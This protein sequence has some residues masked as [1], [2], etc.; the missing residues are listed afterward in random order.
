[1]GRAGH[2]LGAVPKGIVYP[3]TRDDLVQCAA[4]VRAIRAGELDRVLLPEKP[5]DILAQHIVATVASHA[6]P[7][8]DAYVQPSLLDLPEAETGQSGIAEDDLWRLVRRAYPYRGLERAEFNDV[9]KMLSDGI[10]TRMGRRSALLHHDRIHRRLRARRGA[11]LSA[12]TNGGAIPDTADYDVVE[13]PAET[14]VGKVNEDF[15]IESLAGD[16]FLLGNRSWRIHRVSSGKVWVSDAKGSPPTI[17]FWLGEA[18]ARTVELSAA[19]SDLRREI[20]CRF[21]E[22]AAAVRWLAQECC[23]DE[24]AAQQVVTYVAETARALGCV[25]TADCIVAERFFDEAGGMQLVLH[26]PLGGRINR[27]WGLA[28]RKRFCV[29]FN[30][31]IQAAATDDGI[32]LSLGEQHSFPLPEVFSWLRISSTE[33]ALRQAALAS[34]MFVNRWRWNA[35]RALAVQRFRNGKKVPMAIQRFRAEDLLAAVFPEQAGCQDNRTGPVE[36]P[37]HP[38]VDQTMLDCLYEAMDLEGLLQMLG[39]IERGE[40]R[41]VAVETTAPSPMAHEIL[42]ANPY[43][44]LDD[45]PLEERRARAVALR[46][47]DPDLAAGLGVLDP[48]AIE[49]VRAQAWPDLRDSDELHDFLLSVCLLPVPE[50]VHWRNL[51]DELIRSGRGVQASWAAHGEDGAR[52]VYVATERVAVIRVLLPQAQIEPN[53]QYGAEDDP[54]VEEEAIRRTVQGWMEVLGPT[55]AQRL[56]QLLGLS[57][58]QVER[59]LLALEASGNVLR[60]QFETGA[61]DSVRSLQWCDRALLARIHRLTLGRLRSEIEPVSA[62]EFIKFLFRW[63]HVDAESRLRGREGLLAVIGQLQGVEL[64][65]PAWEQAVLATRIEDYD[66]AELEQ[67]CLAGL[68]AWGRIKSDFDDGS[69]LPLEPRQRKNRKRTLSRVAPIAFLIRDNLERF[70]EP[71]TRP[72]EEFG[73]LSPAARSV[74]QYLEQRGASFL[75]DIARGT[76]LLK[77]QAEEGLW[78]LVAHG[79]ATGDGIAGLRVLL[80]PEVKRLPRRRLR[81]IAGGKSGE[82]LMP[83]GRWSLWRVHAG[84]EKAPDPDRAN[85]FLARQLLHRYGILVRELL[86]RESLKI[87]WRALLQALRRLEARGEIRGGRFVSGFVGE[88]YALPE[89]VE[90]LRAMRR[91]GGKQGAVIVS[92]ADPLNLVGILTPGARVSPYSNQVIAYVDGV[93]V[94]IGPLGAVRSRLQL[95]QQSSE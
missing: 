77:T 15:A 4:A 74:A 18:P 81:L 53:P 8:R 5:L 34:P 3:L 11:R 90:A 64:P 23:L 2:W 79:L 39:K 16:I 26:A 19:V 25:P 45:A 91:A 33:A 41:T 36:I 35:T 40:V 75:N 59:G 29:T 84:A 72:W 38:L 88:Q 1:V 65:A 44:F 28:L 49:E 52:H 37:N 46:R 68:V 17:P 9:L 27:A 50:A 80:K 54:P 42:N 20:A 70:L 95:A 22:P 78:E 94:E 47:T 61:T 7:S 69:E 31:E 89:A 92:A 24:A 86:L 93:P 13:L 67:L 62:A 12:I 21:H 85:E 82:R 14:F 71:V 10:A 58:A 60:G 76:G 63:Q 30:N 87:S 66:P 48:Q 43:A 83:V 55:T 32:V 6:K 56:A 51:A 73:V 57:L